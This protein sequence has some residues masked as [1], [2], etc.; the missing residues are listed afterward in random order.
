MEE[1]VYDSKT[2]SATYFAQEKLIKLLWKAESSTNEYRTMFQTI[3]DFAKK[4]KV[5]FIIS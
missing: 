4:K 3:V 5:R 2:V 1:L